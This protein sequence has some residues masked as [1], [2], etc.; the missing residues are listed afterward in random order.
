MP[1]YITEAEVSRLVGMSDALAAV[2]AGFLRWGSGDTAN[3]P[4]RRLALPGAVY[5][6]MA[7]SL[8]DD[9]VFGA[10]AYYVLPAGRSFTVFLHSLSEGRL[11]AM[12]EADW[13]SQLRTGAA[14]GVAARFM[15]RPDASRVGIIGSGTQA[16]AQLMALAA[17]RDLDR[18]AVFSRDAVRRSAFADA[19]SKELGVPVRPVDNAAACVATADMVVTI[20]HASEPLFSGRDLRP[21]TFVAAAGAN[22]LARREIDLETVRR[23]ALVAVDDPEQ[24]RLESGE[25]TAAVEA[26][27]LDWADIVPFGDVVSGRRPA[28]AAGRA[29]TADITLFKSLGIAIEDVAFARIVYEKALAA[30]AG[31]RF[32]D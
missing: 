21:G 6:T 2:E 27:I 18:V 12:I 9:D 31:Q 4:R 23:A 10:K 11:L 1:L 7:A 20:T 14:T 24:A 30:G 17:V 15:A 29:G 19:M 32:G 16:R 22:R 28:C 8:P 5:Q 25:L 13:M 3:L 26:G